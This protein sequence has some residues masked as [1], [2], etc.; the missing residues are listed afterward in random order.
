MF[1]SNTL[2]LNTSWRAS[3]SW[4]GG[5]RAARASFTR[6]KNNDV[7][8]A[9]SQYT[10]KLKDESI[11]RHIYFANQKLNKQTSKPQGLSLFLVRTV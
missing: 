11:I 10:S 5:R 9:Q 4:D 2:K 7:F 8:V 6:A 3:E 1:R